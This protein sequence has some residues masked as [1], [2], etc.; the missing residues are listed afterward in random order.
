MI[1]NISRLEG[2]HA[3]RQKEHNVNTLKLIP[4]LEAE[5]L[6]T[7]WATHLGFATLLAKKDVNLALVEGEKVYRD[8]IATQVLLPE[9]KELFERRILFVKAAIQA[10]HKVLPSEGYEILMP[11]VT[12]RVAI[13][14]SE[15]H[16]W[17]CHNLLT[18]NAPYEDCPHNRVAPCWQPYYFKGRTDAV[19]RWDGMIWLLEHKTSSDNKGTFWDQ[20]YLDWQCTGYLYGIWKAT[21]IRPQ[22]F[23]LN[24]INKPNKRQDPTQVSIQREPFLRSDEDLQR[25]EKEFLLR[26]QDYEESMRLGRIWLNPDNCVSWSRRCDFHK[27][28]M[29]HQSFDSLAYRA[30]PMDYVEEEYYTLLNLDKED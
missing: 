12:F 21:G 16:C 29:D 30:K 8:R 9:E 22:G 2:F 13:P 28:C 24:K 1:A 26:A 3:C 27:K 20:W 4:L 11:E 23:I 14:N 15:H 18:P 19:V 10:Y 25:F 7:G 6:V 17:Y 5:P